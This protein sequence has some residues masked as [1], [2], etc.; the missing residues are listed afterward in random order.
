MSV[1][2]NLRIA[3]FHRLSQCCR[4]SMLAR[5]I[6][7]QKTQ[8]RLAYALAL[9][10]IDL[11]ASKDGPVSAITRDDTGFEHCISLSLFT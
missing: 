8:I 11:C 3:N 5:A 6:T 1:L 4:G 9:A 10:V 7:C 2:Q